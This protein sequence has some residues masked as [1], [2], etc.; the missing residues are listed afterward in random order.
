MTFTFYNY[1]HAIYEHQFRL[2]FAVNITCG[3]LMY[4]KCTA[5]R[6]LVQHTDCVN[7]CDSQLLKN[8]N[9]VVLEPE[10]FKKLR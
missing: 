7:D 1:R 3:G 9:N 5:E 8:K 2:V 4:K 6:I 10:F